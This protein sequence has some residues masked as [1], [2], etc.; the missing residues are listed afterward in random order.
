MSNE[1]PNDYLKYPLAV[2]VKNL[3]D[4]NYVAKIEQC[5][6]G[7][8]A[9]IKVLDIKERFLQSLRDGYAGF[10]LDKSPWIAAFDNNM[11][12][13]INGLITDKLVESG[14]YPDQ[15]TKIACIYFLTDTIFILPTSLL[16]E[17]K[18]T[19]DYCRIVHDIG[20]ITQKERIE[21]LEKSVEMLEQQVDELKTELA[22]RPGGMGYIATAQSFEKFS[23][24]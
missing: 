1:T 7:V 2:Q 24:G 20:E 17:R 22:Y 11:I 14:L 9:K 8:L 6:Q 3:I 15:N 10:Q 5:Y 16:I 19:P 18:N 13:M 23:R 4:T 21:L 12:T